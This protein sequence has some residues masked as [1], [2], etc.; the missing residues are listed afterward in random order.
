MENRTKQCL[1][2]WIAKLKEHGAELTYGELEDEISN[3]ADSF[4]TIDP[5][6]EASKSPPIMR[7][8]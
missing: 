5:F 3:E 2:E 6:G 8:T 7:S 1:D 4:A